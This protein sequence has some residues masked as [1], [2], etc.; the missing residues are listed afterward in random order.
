MRIPAL[1]AAVLVLVLAQMSWAQ[2]S[3]AKD[4]VNDDIATVQRLYTEGHFLDAVAMGTRLGTVAGL[5]LA[6]RSLIV[7]GEYVAKPGQQET[8]FQSALD[9]ATR[10]LEKDPDDLE[11]HLQSVN[12]LGHIS[13]VRGHIESHFKGYA[14]IAKKHLKRAKK[15]G[16][17][18]RGPTPSMAPGMP[19]LRSMLPVSSRRSIMGRAKRKPCAIT[20]GRSTWTP[21][22]LCF[23]L[24]TGMLF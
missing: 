9:A 1:A 4:S 5:N 15:I 21:K 14:K 24:N 23:S 11:G 22:I 3:W 7:H 10:A 6:A 18:T 19:R 12:A 17:E 20:S 8:F 13:R 16:P 2:A